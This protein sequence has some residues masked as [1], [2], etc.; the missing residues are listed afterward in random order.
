MNPRCYGLVEMALSFG[1]VA[2][3]VIHQFWTL[4]DRK[5]PKDDASE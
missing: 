5:P 2:V 1:A 4:R 3:F